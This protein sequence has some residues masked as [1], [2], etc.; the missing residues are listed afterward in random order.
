MSAVLAIS[1]LTLAG[2]LSGL[3]PARKAATLQP[4]DALRQ[5]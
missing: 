3:Y 5:E 1:S 4:V 2:V